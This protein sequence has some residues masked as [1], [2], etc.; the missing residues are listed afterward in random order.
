MENYLEEE[1]LI[2]GIEI[3]YLYVCKTKLW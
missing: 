1:L 2:K 3:N